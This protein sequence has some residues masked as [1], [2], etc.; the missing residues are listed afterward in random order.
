MERGNVQVPGRSNSD[1]PQDLPLRVAREH[2]AMTRDA[3]RRLRS[4]S[5]TL[6]ALRA[7]ASR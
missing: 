6:D 1:L 3:P 7:V 4:V 5:L 2:A